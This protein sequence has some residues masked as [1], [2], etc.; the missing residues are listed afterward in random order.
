MEIQNIPF[1]FGL[2]YA[3]IHVVTGPDHLAAV[4]PLAINARMRS[5]IIGMA[6]GIGH[7]VG[8]LLIG[9][10]FLLFR[11]FINV[12]AISSNS[13]FLVGFLLIGIGL[14]ALIRFIKDKKREAKGKLHI[15]TNAEGDKYAHFHV[16]KGSHHH[17][18]SGKKTIGI[19]LGIGVLHGLAGV[20]HLIGLLPTLAFSS[21]TES[22]LYLTG[23]GIGTIL[24][25][26]LF[27][28]LLGLIGHYA[29]KKNKLQLT[30]L[31]NVSAGSLAIIVGLF[32]IWFS[33]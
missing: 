3:A 19:S 18:N 5:W 15:H 33:F 24:A 32:W 26:V 14:W 22:L 9:T 7:V 10:L 8:M 23:F 21:N 6:W 2:V 4:G 28:L 20:S 25:M 11:E 12:E 16:A 30:H 27:S 31:L 13:E 17:Q 29:N 1:L